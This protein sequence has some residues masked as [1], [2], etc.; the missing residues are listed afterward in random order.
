[1]LSK[2]KKYKIEKW[3][4]VWFIL[5]P[6]LNINYIITDRMEV[7]GMNIDIILDG[8]IPFIPMFVLP[9]VYWY[10]YMGFGLIFLLLKDRKIYIKTFL[11]LIIGMCICYVIYFI[12]PTEITRPEIVKDG[13]FNNIVKI[14]YENDRPFNCFPSLHVLGTYII[15]RYIKS[16]YSR[17]WFEYTQI[18]GVMIILSTLF[19]K[20]HFVLDVLASIILG[21]ILILLVQAVDDKC[22]EFIINIPRWLKSK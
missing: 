21:E 5:I 7:T 10:L 9:Y 3:D 19:I 16:D 4:L 11:T 20:Q 6:L 14:V 15:M 22:V 1:M 8:M 13:I 18:V 17:V 2:I 12:F